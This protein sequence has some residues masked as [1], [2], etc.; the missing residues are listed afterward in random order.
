MARPRY[1][2]TISLT[3]RRRRQVLDL[4]IVRRSIGA[5]GP[6]AALQ[7]QA[8]WVYQASGGKFFGVERRNGGVDLNARVGGSVRAAPL[9]MPRGGPRLHDRTV[10]ARGQRLPGLLRR[11]HRHRGNRAF[12]G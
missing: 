8:F 12:R 7:D 1:S 11:G 6:V 5:M 4:N 2:R 10:R 9:Q 3:D